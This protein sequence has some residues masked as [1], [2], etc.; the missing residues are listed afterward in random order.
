MT[1]T[2]G[3]WEATGTKAGGLSEVVAPNS[4]F[5][6]GH[7]V[8]TINGTYFVEG[9]SFPKFLPRVQR[10]ANARLI[11]AAPELLAVCERTLAYFVAHEPGQPILLLAD[12]RSAIAKAKGGS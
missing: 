4:D 12:L 3:P 5:H 6:E 1:H 10:E 7:L 2:P 9:G 8:A 11:A